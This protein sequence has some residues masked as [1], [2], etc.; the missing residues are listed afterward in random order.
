MQEA[1]ERQRNANALSHSASLAMYLVY[2]YGKRRRQT[3]TEMSGVIAV[4]DHIAD[5]RFTE[6]G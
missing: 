4:S 2:W 5:V 3:S 6:S 1:G